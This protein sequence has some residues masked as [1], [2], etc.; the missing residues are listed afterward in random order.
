M[1]LLLTTT[2]PFLFSWLPI[3][4]EIKARHL[5]SVT[6]SNSSSNSSVSELRKNRTIVFLVEALPFSFIVFL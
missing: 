3:P 4:A 5:V 1:L 6:T 2:F